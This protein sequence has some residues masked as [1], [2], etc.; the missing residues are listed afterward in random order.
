[1]RCPNCEASVEE[2]SR[3]CNN[4]GFAIAEQG[5]VPQPVPPGARPPVAYGKPAKDPNTAL[6][7]ELVGTLFGF[8]GL[9]WLYAGYTNRGITALVLWLIVVVVAT[10]ISV[11]TGGFFACLW[12][13]AQI[14]AAVISGMQVKQAVER[15]MK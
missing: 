9:G 14:A 4:C 2:G 13:P 3:F 8:M 5:P 1:M 15:D 6:L 11:F 7:I 12:L 10:V